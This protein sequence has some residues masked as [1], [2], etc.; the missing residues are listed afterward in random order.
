MQLKKGIDRNGKTGLNHSMDVRRSEI[1]SWLSLLSKEGRLTFEKLNFCNIMDL[2]LKLSISKV[3]STIVQD[4]HPDTA[5]RMIR[6][7][8][9]KLQSLYLGTLW[10][11][12]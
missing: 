1:A 12:A 10:L 8:P 11:K 5:R 4:V 6:K 2:Q 9:G 7:R 3:T